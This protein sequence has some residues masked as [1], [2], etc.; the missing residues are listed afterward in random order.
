[1]NMN[2]NRAKRTC[3]RQE[4]KAVL[5]L[6][7]ENNPNPDAIELNRLSLLVQK[8]TD[9]VLNW[10]KN[11]RARLRRNG[12]E[13]IQGFLMARP[14]L[15][16]SNNQSRPD[17]VGRVFWTKR[18][19]ARLTEF[20]ELNRNPNQAEIMA[21]AIEL[22]TEPIKVQNWIKNHRQRERERLRV[23]GQR[24]P[25]SVELPMVNYKEED[26]EIDVEEVEESPT[27]VSSSASSGNS[28]VRYAPMCPNGVPDTVSRTPVYP[29]AQHYA[30]M[31]WW[32]RQLAYAAHMQQQLRQINN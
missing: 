6:S 31:I 14:Q 13:P 29:N 4:E 21:L 24:S 30:M 9:R 20:Y 16:N 22:N 10:F 5:K 32:Q 1:M 23:A 26:E 2:M 7:F 18:A 28:E 11:E 17:R 15:N 19:R 8:D 12:L 3:W 25:V 27:E